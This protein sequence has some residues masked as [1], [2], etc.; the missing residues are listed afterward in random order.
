MAFALGFLGW[1]Q[2]NAEEGHVHAGA[3]ANLSQAEGQVFTCPM[4]SE[5]TQDKP[6]SCPKC[7]MNLEPV[8][9]A[10]SQT[11]KK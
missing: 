3:G 4:H 10:Y 2:A 8:E 5:V 1:T 11:K 7:G 9:E 6:G